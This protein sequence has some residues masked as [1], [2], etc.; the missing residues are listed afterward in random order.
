MDGVLVG[1]SIIFDAQ[2]KNWFRILVGLAAVLALLDIENHSILLQLQMS[3][4]RQNTEQPKRAGFQP[5]TN[6]FWLELH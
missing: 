6:P 3:V 5:W 4:K 2:G 1:L